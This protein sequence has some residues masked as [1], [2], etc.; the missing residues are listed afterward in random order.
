MSFES[1]VKGANSKGSK[2]KGKGN[3]YPSKKGRFD[4]KGHCLAV[5]KKV[6]QRMKAMEQDT[7][8]WRRSQ[9]PHTISS[10]LALVSYLGLAQPTA[11]RKYRFD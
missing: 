10:C 2:D 3:S 6:M 11:T 7:A 4:D 8:V 5:E 9:K 1:G